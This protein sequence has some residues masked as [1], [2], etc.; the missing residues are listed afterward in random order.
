MRYNVFIKNLIPLHRFKLIMAKL[1]MEKLVNDSVKYV[2]LWAVD[3][4][5]AY[6][7]F[8]INSARSNYLFTY[9]VLLLLP[10]RG[11]IQ[12]EH[13][14]CS[15]FESLELYINSVFVPFQ[16]VV[17]DNRFREFI[18]T[19]IHLQQQKVIG[20]SFKKVSLRPGE[21]LVSFD[22]TDLCPSV[23]I[24]QILK[25]LEDLLRKNTEN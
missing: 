21:V 23:P 6:W 16:F 24:P 22:V 15:R 1:L 7:K 2:L 17:V 3:V 20:V 4:F 11:T 8:Q 25:Y 19:V 10:L 9:R 13:T 12:R 18:A 14:E 5:C